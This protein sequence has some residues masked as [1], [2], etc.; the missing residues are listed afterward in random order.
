MR[1]ECRECGGTFDGPP[2]WVEFIPQWGGDGEG[3]GGVETR[4][5]V[6]CRACG[7]FVTHGVPYELGRQLHRMGAVWERAEFEELIYREG[8]KL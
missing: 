5:A 6:T 7:G 8:A 3:G 1:G 4:V 2:V